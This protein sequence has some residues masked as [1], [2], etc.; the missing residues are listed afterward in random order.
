MTKEEIIEELEQL[1]KSKLD[2]LAAV[3]AK[4]LALTGF[5]AELNHIIEKVR[6]DNA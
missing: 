3:N 4:H 5:I 1:K 2:E 6:N